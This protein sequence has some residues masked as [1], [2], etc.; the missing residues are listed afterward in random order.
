MEFKTRNLFS[1]EHLSG[2]AHGY[3][4][5]TLCLSSYSKGSKGGVGKV[6]IILNLCS[7]GVPATQ[8]LNKSNAHGVLFL[9]MN[10][11]LELGLFPAHFS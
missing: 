11:W 9:L 7:F 4:A 3:H 5:C 2:G 8:V 10:A 1:E 6:E